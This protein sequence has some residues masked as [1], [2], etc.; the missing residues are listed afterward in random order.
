MNEPT[1]AMSETGTGRPVLLLHGG[2]G[3]FTVGALA[4]HLAKSCHVLTATLPGWNGTPRPP[5]LNR[6]SQLAELC[7]RY[8]EE[9]EL[10]NVL[11]VGSSLGG[12]IAAEMALQDRAHR[13]SGLVVINGGGVDVPGQTIAD[14]SSLSPQELAALSFHDPSKLP[15]PPPPTEEQKAIRVGNLRALAAFA[16]NPYMHDPTLMGRLP[17]LR[18]PALFIWGE[19]D[20]VISPVYGR[21]FAAAVPGSTFALVPKAGHLPWMEQPEAV[22]AIL[23]PFVAVTR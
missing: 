9:K 6:V 18:L 22:Q 3:P 15:T 8:L 13:L 11:V 17:S 16:S 20:R 23:D 2:G 4:A 19:S 14:V 5:T 12:W 1:L 21:A 7:L 10:K